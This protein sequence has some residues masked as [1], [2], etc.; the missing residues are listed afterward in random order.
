MIL[1]QLLAKENKWLRLLEMK[2]RPFNVRIPPYYLGTQCLLQLAELIS[3][4]SLKDVLSKVS[5]DLF[6]VHVLNITLD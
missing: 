2:R 4:L 5:T 1:Y 6:P 3:K